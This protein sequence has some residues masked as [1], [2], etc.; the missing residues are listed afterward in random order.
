MPRFLEVLTTEGNAIIHPSKVACVL[1]DPEQADTCM[2]R[3]VDGYSFEVSGS[4]ESVVK[5]LWMQAL[6]SWRDE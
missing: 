6:Q 5:K 4:G 3:L 2:L 1:S